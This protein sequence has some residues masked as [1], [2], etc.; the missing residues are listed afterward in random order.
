[1][2]IKKVLN[3]ATIEQ[4]AKEYGSA[5]T[6]AAKD[7]NAGQV[8]D[9]EEPLGMMGRELDAALAAAREAN[10]FGEI[11]GVNV[12]F[13]GRGGTGKTYTVKKWAQQ[14]GINLVEK[15]AKTM[16]PSDLGGV[17]ARRYDDEG[18]PTNTVTKLSNTE[19]DELDKPNS[20]LFLDEL[21]RARK[22]V[23]GA[24]LTL[25]NDHVIN[26]QTQPSGKRLLKGFLFTIAAINPNKSGNEVN[27]LDNPMR[28]RFKTV[29][30]ESDPQ[31]SIEH[32]EY[33]FGKQ[34]EKLKAMGKPERI[35]VIQGRLELAKKLLSD[36]RFEFDGDDEEEI[37]QD[38]GIP[39]LNPRSFSRLLTSTDGT[40]QSLLDNWDG[41]CNPA[42]HN[43]VEDILSDYVDVDDK[44]NDALRYGDDNPFAKAKAAQRAQKSVYDQIA[45]VL[46]GI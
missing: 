10:D 40:K 26:D 13:V 3:E 44:A 19:F 18:N 37:A 11:G 28:S 46:P 6:K 42:K 21:N 24:L 20:V 35:P 22:D 33:K 38:E 17:V 30:V 45:D 43:V 31:E 5:V 27:S 16:D 8:I 7:V 1:M 36:P 25:I 29:E 15:D 41:F 2:K 39:V 34:I 32:F 14:R 9:G 12:L 23:A 4:A